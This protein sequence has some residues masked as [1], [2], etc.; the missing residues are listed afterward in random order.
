MSEDDGVT[1]SLSGHLFDT[2][3]IHKI[4]D[5]LYELNGEFGIQS[6]SLGHG[7]Q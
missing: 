6:W 1:L 5:L 2:K 4:L 3:S 7:A